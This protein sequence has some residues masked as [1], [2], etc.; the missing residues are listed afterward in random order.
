MVHSDEA[1]VLNQVKQFT[2]TTI[3]HPVPIFNISTII[4]LI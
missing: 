3:S 1:F 4:V 2:L